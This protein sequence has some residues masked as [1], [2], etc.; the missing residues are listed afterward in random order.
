MTF[1]R[2]LKRA[3]ERALRGYS[4]LDPETA[5][6]LRIAIRHRFPRIDMPMSE[7]DL[8]QL[9]TLKDFAREQLMH[10]E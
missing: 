9:D 10:Y 6:F 7:E 4:L 5:Y 8:I 3:R 2:K 1:L